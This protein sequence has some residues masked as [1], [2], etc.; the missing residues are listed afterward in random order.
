ML[1][2]THWV[3]APGQLFGLKV[4]CSRITI[5][6]GRK[7]LKIDIYLQ[8]MCVPSACVRNRFTFIFKA[9]LKIVLYRAFRANS[10]QLFLSLRKQLRMADR[11]IVKHLGDM[12]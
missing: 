3:F 4:H 8:H 9:Y 12:E 6:I 2:L 11:I 1:V 10:K 5:K 7:I